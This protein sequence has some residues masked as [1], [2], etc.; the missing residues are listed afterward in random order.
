MLQ[1]N[2]LSFLKIS[3]SRI[4]FKKLGIAQLTLTDELLDLR[5]VHDVELDDASVMAVGMKTV[6]L[7]ELEFVVSSVGTKKLLFEQSSS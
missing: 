6:L 4:E 3:F 7:T 5:V 1:V 2:G